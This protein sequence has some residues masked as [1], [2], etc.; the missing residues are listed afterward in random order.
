MLYLSDGF[1]NLVSHPPLISLSKV[2]CFL[3]LVRHL[4]AH[5]VSLC[6]GLFFCSMFC[7]IW[8]LYDFRCT[9][10][11]SFSFISFFF[12]HSFIY[13][14]ILATFLLTILS[15][16]PLSLISSAW[17]QHDSCPTGCLLVFVHILTMRWNNNSI[18]INTCCLIIEQN[19][20]KRKNL[21]HTCSHSLSKYV[22]NI[23][24]EF[25]MHGAV[26]EDFM[27]IQ[28]KLNRL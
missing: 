11:P 28:L 8:R 17:G 6:L 23:S 14:K 4:I 19:L 3:I 26:N 24:T 9:D 1:S 10:Y 5:F 27:K 15:V 16:A 13:N 25:K 7:G 21:Q 18:A 22:I 2:I 12:I 20:K